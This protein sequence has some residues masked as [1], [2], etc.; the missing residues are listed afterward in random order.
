MEQLSEEINKK[1]CFFFSR[2]KTVGRVGA[3]THSPSVTVSPK[4]ERNGEAP[5]WTVSSRWSQLRNPRGYIHIGT[6]LS[7]KRTLS[8]RM[9]H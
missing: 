5:G 6:I 9:F 8:M 7:T 1:K 3:V 2:V 4:P